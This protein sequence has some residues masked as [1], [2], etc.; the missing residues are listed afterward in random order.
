M[1][2]RLLVGKVP[3]YGPILGVYTVFMAG[4]NN[5]S[6]IENIYTNMWFGDKAHAYKGTHMRSRI[7]PGGT[8]HLRHSRA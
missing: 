6:V 5:P 8:E 3:V 7:Y 4:R 2:S 1:R